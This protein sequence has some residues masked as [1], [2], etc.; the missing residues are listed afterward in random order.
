M[1]DF[2]SLEI[3]GLKELM[4]KMADYPE[5]L[6]KKAIE[7]AL[8]EITEKIRDKAK[9][10]ILKDCAEYADK[11]RKKDGTTKSRATGE[12]AKHIVAVPKTKGLNKHEVARAVIVRKSRKISVKSAFKSFVKVGKSGELVFTGKLKGKHVRK[13]SSGKRVRVSAY[14]AH[15]VEYGTKNMQ[16]RPF[17]RP[18][19]KAVEAKIPEIFAKHIKAVDDEINRVI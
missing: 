17:L 14:Y 2:M 6:K 1:A 10:N 11:H 8:I 3:A 19:S 12:L 16:K 9:Q 18:A 4:A 13:T 15:F 7:P 5:K